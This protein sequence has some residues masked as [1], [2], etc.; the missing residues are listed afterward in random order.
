MYEYVD[1]RFSA[2][3]LT[4]DPQVIICTV[5]GLGASRRAQDLKHSK[6]TD[7]GTRFLI[8]ARYLGFLARP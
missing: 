3:A 5:R 2:S 7:D 6:V 4:M 8:G 1:Y